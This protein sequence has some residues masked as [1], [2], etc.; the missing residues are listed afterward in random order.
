VIDLLPTCLDAAGVEYPQTH[1]GRTVAPPDGKSLLPIFRGET[2]QGHDVLYWKFAHGRAVRQ[3]DWK[4]VKMDNEPWE[5]YD[6]G[7]DPVELND[8]AS[9]MP[10]QVETLAKRWQDWAGPQATKKKRKAK[11]KAP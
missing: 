6:L 5:L 1:G 7:A 8:L 4:L 9:K 10:E 11:K 3:G 2:R